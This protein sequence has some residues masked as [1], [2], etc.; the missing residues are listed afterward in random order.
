MWIKTHGYLFGSH[1]LLDVSSTSIYISRFEKETHL[2]VQVPQ[3][4]YDVV[5]FLDREEERVSPPYCSADLGPE[6]Q[7]L[8]KVKEDL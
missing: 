3:C 4:W 6:F 7:C 2:K 1:E 8:L 5:G